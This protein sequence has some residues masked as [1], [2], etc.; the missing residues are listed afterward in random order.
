MKPA[1]R[2]RIP[3]PK[4]AAA[5]NGQTAKPATPPPTATID[6]AEIDVADEELNDNINF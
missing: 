2:V 1:L 4:Q 6:P 5:G 3:P